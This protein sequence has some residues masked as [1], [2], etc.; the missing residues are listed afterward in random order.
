MATHRKARVR[1]WTA[2]T[3][4]AL[5]ARPGAKAQ[6]P[7]TGQPASSSGG[8]GGAVGVQTQQCQSPE[9]PTTEK[10]TYTWVTGR[11]VS[12]NQMEGGNGQV[13]RGGLSFC[14]GPRSPKKLLMALPGVCGGGDHARWSSP[15]VPL[16]EVGFGVP[17]SCLGAVDKPHPSPL[18]LSP[19]LAWPHFSPVLM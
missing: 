18:P 10:R 14:V 12:G 7:H 15:D 4:R 8:Q 1:G 9:K 16:G 13:L 19:C 6:T 5:H 3:H 17:Q 2:F 11:F